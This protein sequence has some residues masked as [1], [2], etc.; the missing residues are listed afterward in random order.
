M[1]SPRCV[2]GGVTHGVISGV[3]GQG[4]FAGSFPTGFAGSSFPGGRGPAGTTGSG[5]GGI[6][7]TSGA[8]GCPISNIAPQDP[9]IA[10]F[11][12]AD[13]STVLPIGGTFTYAAPSG[14]AG[15]NATITN[16]ALHIT[17]NDHG[18]A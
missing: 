10:I 11:D 16:G 14:T 7:G 12:E 5:G 8:L 2:G 1:I 3:G 9:V 13:G 6:G 4:G 18:H 15:P 17:R